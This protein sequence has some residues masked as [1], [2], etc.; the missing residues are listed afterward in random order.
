VY[1]NWREKILPKIEKLANTTPLYVEDDLYE[2]EDVEIY[3]KEEVDISTIHFNVQG[4]Y[5]IYAQ[6]QNQR[7]GYILH[8]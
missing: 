4:L 5:N 7:G 3:D 6:N 8:V 1:R 2:Y